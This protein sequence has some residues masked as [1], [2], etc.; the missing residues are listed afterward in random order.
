MSRSYTSS[1]TCAFIGVLWDC[2]TFH[3]LDKT[4]LEYDEVVGIYDDHNKAV[5]F[6]TTESLLAC[7]RIVFFPGNKLELVISSVCD[8]SSDL[9]CLRPQAEKRR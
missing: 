7:R 2:F 4:G 6:I 1:L 8:F 3:D 9:L 5:L